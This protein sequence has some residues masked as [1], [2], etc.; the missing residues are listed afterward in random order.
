MDARELLITIANVFWQK[1]SFRSS[2]A[3]YLKPFYWSS[4]WS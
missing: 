2:R 3:F 1:S 4:D